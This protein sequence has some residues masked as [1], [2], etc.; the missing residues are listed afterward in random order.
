MFV[1]I[2]YFLKNCSMFECSPISKS[3][4]VQCSLMFD[5]LNDIFDIQMFKVK[6]Y[7]CSLLLKCSNVRK[8]RSLK[9]DLFGCSSSVSFK[10]SK[11]K[12]WKWD[13]V[14]R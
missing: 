7:E 12:E 11:S 3:S 6:F 8:K 9:I 10:M 5:F 14:L 13:T 2:R 4:D 1:N